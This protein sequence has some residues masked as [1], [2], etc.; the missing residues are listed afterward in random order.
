MALTCHALSQTVHV[1]LQDNGH[2][3]WHVRHATGLPYHYP[4]PVT[5]PRGH[6]LA[7]TQFIANLTSARAQV[8]LLAQRAGYQ[9]LDLHGLTTPSQWAAAA[10]A[11]VRNAAAL[12]AAMLRVILGAT[13]IK[14]IV[15][16]PR[17][18]RIP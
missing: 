3:L 14:L 5:L 12:E 15:R 6:F 7:E 4:V 10:A 13:G 2:F 8:G 11:S 18:D 1:S 9:A 16:G 17:H